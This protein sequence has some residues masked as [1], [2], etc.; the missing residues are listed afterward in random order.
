MI[1]NRR[2]LITPSPPLPSF[3]PRDGTDLLDQK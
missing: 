1:A 2:G 3:C